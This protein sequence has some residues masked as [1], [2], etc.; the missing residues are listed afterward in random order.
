MGAGCRN[1]GATPYC[2]TFRTPTHLTRSDLDEIDGPIS[3]LLFPLYDVVS[4][5][6]AHN[7]AIKVLAECFEHTKDHVGL[8]DAMH[9]TLEHATDNLPEV[10]PTNLEQHVAAVFATAEMAITELEDAADSH[11]AGA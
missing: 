1:R 4:R 2:A 6:S 10:A 5:F 11:R 3:P 9:D 7:H 8:A